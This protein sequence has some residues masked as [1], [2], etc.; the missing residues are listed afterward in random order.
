MISNVFSITLD[1]LLQ[2]QSLNNKG[3][4]GCFDQM[5]F[6]LIYSDSQAVNKRGSFA[7][8]NL[9][10]IPELGKRVTRKEKEEIMA[11]RK[12]AENCHF[13]RKI[14]NM[15]VKSNTQHFNLNEL[16]KT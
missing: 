15:V 2:G 6:D 12:T 13:R 3:P 1:S 4:D 14:Q 10:P 16:D 8:S 9:Y 5:R 7:K 11:N